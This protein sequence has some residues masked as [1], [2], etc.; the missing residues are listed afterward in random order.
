MV[1]EFGDDDLVARPETAAQGSGEMESER[2]HVGAEGDFVRRGVEKISQGAARRGDNGIG[3]DTGRVGPVRIGVVVEK[4]VSH[5]V[6]DR[7]RDLGPART[8][9]VGDWILAV[10][11]LK[12]WEMPSDFGKGTHR[13]GGGWIHKGD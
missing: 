12:G 9:K 4:I 13:C 7:G 11:S 2:R 8:I 3:L 6:D 5:C 10:D 1:V